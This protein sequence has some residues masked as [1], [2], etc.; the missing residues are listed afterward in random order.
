SGF[1]YG[2]FE[3]RGGT[4]REFLFNYTVPQPT[5]FFR[6][7][8]LES[9]G[10]LDVSYS[11]IYDYDLFMRFARTGKVKKL[12]RTQ[13]LCRLAE[14]EG[15]WR[16][17]AMLGEL[18]RHNRRRWPSLWSRAF[19]P[20]LRDFVRSFLARKF[21]LPMSR[22]KRWLMK[23]FLS[24][25]AG[26]RGFNPER[27]QLGHFPVAGRP[28]RLQVPP[29]PF[30]TAPVA[31]TAVPAARS[32]QGAPSRRAHS[33]LRF[34]SLVC[35]PHLPAH[36]G[37]SSAE[38]RDFHM[39]RRLMEISSVQFFA[40]H[41]APAPPA[42]GRLGPV[43]VLYTPATMTLLRPDLGALAKRRPPRRTPPPTPPR[44]PP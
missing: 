44:R 38:E 18:Y 37:R 5:F 29:P 12:E 40:H 31:L 19:R 1:C 42:G 25:L 2:T 3:K 9:H 32:G 11:L 33:T 21:R 15:P 16:W 10:F 20:C 35:A 24:L 7:R 6:R 23:G 26:T 34:N 36:P 43:D 8:L 39:L 22:L 13:A 28:S 4:N 14:S 17:N 30:L 27:W 41:P